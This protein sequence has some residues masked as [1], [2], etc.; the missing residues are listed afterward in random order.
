MPLV[1]TIPNI[2]RL[3][4]LVII[5]FLLLWVLVAPGCMTFRTSD[6]KAI[7]SF[8]GKGLDLKT[9]TIKVNKNDIH[10]V[11]V[12]NDT[13]PTMV[14]IHGS[15]SSWNAFQS[16]MEDPKLLSLYRMVGIDR[17]G[18]GYSGFGKAFPLQDQ[19]RLLMPV[20]DK[21]KNGKPIYLAGH[22]LGGP[23]VLKMAADAP[24]VFSGIMLISG[25]VDPAL[26]PVEEWRIFMDKF[27]FR[28]LLPG[29]FRPS[30]TELIYF[31]Q[32]VISLVP[33]FQKVICPV[34]LVHGEK[35]NWVPPGNTTF[36]KEKLVN[37]VKVKLVMLQGGTHFI[38]WTKKK[39]IVDELVEMAEYPL[40]N[41]STTSVIG[42]RTPS[43]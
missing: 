37:S 24:E 10:F 33:D 7:K 8:A 11:S 17:P 3:T 1:S 26:E 35:D 6:E 2:V 36:A 41:R 32:D 18:F 23:L 25:S 20:F 5:A 21:I 31:K 42:K 40:N 15:P 38:P 29:S 22:S 16:Y 30:N 14:F 28:Y 27:P 9:V 12:G 4:F 13:L 43:F 34:Y 19:S 39:E